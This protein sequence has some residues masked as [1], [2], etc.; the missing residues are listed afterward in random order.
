MGKGRER[1]RERE[2]ERDTS[3]GEEERAGVKGSLTKWFSGGGVPN[4][5]STSRTP[6]EYCESNGN[7]AKRENGR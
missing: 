1:E 2:R 6:E 5:S 7:Q 3:S 4:S